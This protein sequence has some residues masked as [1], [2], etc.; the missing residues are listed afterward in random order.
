MTHKLPTRIAVIVAATVL[1]VLAAAAVSIAWMTRALDQQALEQTEVQVEIV[2]ENILSRIDMVTVDY[3]KWDWAYDAVQSGTD[4]EWLLGNIGS[5][6]LIGEAIQLAVIWDGGFTQDLGWVDDGVVEPRSGLVPASTLAAVEDLLSDARPGNFDAAEFFQWRGAE[7]FAMAASH[8]EPVEDPSRVPEEERLGGLLLMGT[9]IDAEAVA[10][11]ARSLS[12]TGTGLALS[13]PADRPSMALAGIDGKPVAYFVWDRPRPGTAMLRRMV[14]YLTL[15]AA[16]AASLAA[17]NV[18]MAKRGALR[19][20]V[21]EQQASRAARTDALT[22][23]PNRGAFNDAIASPAIAG[24]RSVLF[25][26]INDFKRINDSI[27]HA[28]GDQ[29]IIAVAQRLTTIADPRCLLARVGGDEFVFVLTGPHAAARTK[30]L[31]AEAEKLFMQPFCV[32]GYQMRLRAAI[33]YAVQVDNSTTGEDLVRQADLAMYEAKRHR[34]GE[35]VAFSN[36]LDH[37]TQNAAVIEQGLRK[38]LEQPAELSVVYQ[39]IT[40]MDGR[41]VRAEALARWTSPE[42]GSV[43]PDRFIAVAERAGLIVDLGRKIIE[44]VCNDLVAYPDLRISLNISPLQLMS[45]EFIP[46]LIRDLQRY[47][48]AVSRVE[49]ELTE[50]VI[51][52]DT[53][54]A[55]E[56]LGELQAAGFSTSL[57]DFGTGYS[58]MGYLTRLRFQTLKIDRSFVAKIRGSNQDA[59]V[60]EG[61]IR[62]AHGLGL[63]VVCEGIETAE[64]CDRLKKLGCDLAQGYYFDPPLPI[65]TLA[66]RWLRS[67]LPASEPM[68]VV[69][70]LRG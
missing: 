46:A 49:I 37:A 1:L 35:P 10:E 36:I 31:T 53:L 64:E 59:A 66:E 19:L 34:G 40:S 43:S 50:S 47:N 65:A 2:R 67:S 60:V 68:N 17:V 29:V 8:F 62:I 20:V 6:A 54:L 33:G 42:L 63:Q 23:L 58:S 16:A 70:P 24:E 27:G 48:V 21:A 13:P 11:I 15:L 7:L 3:A 25:L 18:R 45:P 38:A 5:A 32:L 41:M 69:V 51:V 14:P 30:D 26:D 61:M 28:A 56:R 4:V 39:P 52:D 44:L 57:D 55:A 22:G 9:R 12:L